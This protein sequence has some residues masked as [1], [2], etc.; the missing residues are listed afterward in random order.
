VTE[1]TA[2]KVGVLLWNQYTDWPSMRDHAA[3]A[4]ALGYESLWTWDHLYPI[5]GSSNGPILEGYGVLAGWAA[6][7]ERATL[8]LMV[9]ANTFRNPA[10]VVKQ[11]TMLDHLS[12]GR[13]VLGIGA[14]WFD[15]EHADFG[16]EFGASVGQRIGWLDESVDL[17]AQMLREGVGT[18]RGDHYGAEH[19]R[20]DPRPVQAR[21]PILIG[22]A[23]EKKTLRT[24]A[25]YADIW[26][27]SMVT[28]EEA[29]RKRDILLEHCREVGRDP[30]EIELTLS[31]GPTF[32]RDD[33]AE[34]ERVRQRYVARN[35]GAQRVP[36]MGNVAE[37]TA[38]FQAFLDVGFRHLIYHLPPPYDDE[39][40]ERFASEVRPALA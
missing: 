23:G 20:N 13:A 33:P 8:G 14:A 34:L 32:I 31:V 21:L 30:E 6:A 40:L 22:G 12:N 29:A 11:I 37:I 38:H 3:R 15:E 16:I 35:A 24:V 27:V 17:M 7:T 1:T 18:A 39:T 4:D 26:N 2:P 36:V 5:Q 19:V 28:P 9:G 25:R 10:L